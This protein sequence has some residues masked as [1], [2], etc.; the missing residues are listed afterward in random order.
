MDEPKSE[1]FDFIWHVRYI[2]FWLVRNWFYQNWKEPNLSLP[3]FLGKRDHMHASPWKTVVDG[4]KFSE[5]A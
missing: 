2:I 4:N 3:T 5:L 1:H